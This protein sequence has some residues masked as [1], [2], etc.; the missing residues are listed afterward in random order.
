[1]VTR[2]ESHNGNPGY[3][4]DSYVVG[5]IGAQGFYS[6]MFIYDRHGLVNPLGGR[7]SAAKHFPNSLLGDKS[8][9]TNCRNSCS[10]SPPTVLPSTEAKTTEASFFTSDDSLTTAKSSFRAQRNR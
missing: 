6:E 10:A 7:R 9:R 8:N 4:F 5:P 3:R 2:I 1:M